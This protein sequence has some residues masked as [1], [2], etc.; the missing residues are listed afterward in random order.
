MPVKTFG[1]YS[2]IRQVGN[3]YFVSGHIGIDPATG[4]AGPDI[5]VQTKQV[6][7]NLRTTLEGAGLTMDGIIKT[8]IFLT[9]IGDFG[10]VNEIYVSYFKEPRPARSTVGV[11]ELPRV[12]KDV[13]LKIEIEA[14]AA[15]TTTSKD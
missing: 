2:P 9:D 10:A 8:T 7:D 13:D 3:L 14:I 12:S 4:T 6:M 5:A 11:K 15:I 1:P